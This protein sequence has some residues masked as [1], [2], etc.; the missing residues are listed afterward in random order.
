MFMLSFRADEWVEEVVWQEVAAAVVADMRHAKIGG[1]A[2][3]LDTIRRGPADATMDMHMS[4]IINI[5][6][7]NI[8]F[9]FNLII[10]KMI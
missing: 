1:N 6:V 2:A 5:L 3:V 9:G 7:T 8:R 10:F 4:H